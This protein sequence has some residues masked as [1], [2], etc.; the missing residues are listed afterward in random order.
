MKLN[1]LLCGALLSAPFLLAAATPQV[2]LTPLALAQVSADTEA[3]AGRVFLEP[4]N[5]ESLNA[6]A[7]T[8]TLFY[9]P[10][11][12]NPLP[13]PSAAGV[14]PEAVVIATATNT[15]LRVPLAP[16]AMVVR[17]ESLL[18]VSALKVGDIV[19][20]SGQKTAYRSLPLSSMDARGGA[21]PIPSELLFRM[22]TELRAASRGEGFTVASLAPLMLKRLSAPTMT[23]PGDALTLPFPDGSEAMRVGALM[24]M[25]EPS[26]T[27]LTT[28]LDSG[29][30]AAKMF[31]PSRYV[32]TLTLTKTDNLVFDRLMPMSLSEASAALA[33]RSLDLRAEFGVASDGQL[34]INRL[35][36]SDLK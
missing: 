33:A 15:L 13:A 26:N 8:A 23:Q 19:T 2:A 11:A 14:S 16:D 1:W 4:I 27:A 6:G 29:L 35:V 7:R 9:A 24:I 22:G 3:G 18:P 36:A 31:A 25:A 10:T 12:T 32:S 21:M 34:V 5:I 28:A 30:S 17:T 20:L